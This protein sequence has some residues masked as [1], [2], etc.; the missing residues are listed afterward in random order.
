MWSVPETVVA[1]SAVLSA[2]WA[3]RGDECAADGSDGAAAGLSKVSSGAAGL[4]NFLGYF[5]DIFY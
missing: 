4:W 3:W 5:L 2:M 1:D